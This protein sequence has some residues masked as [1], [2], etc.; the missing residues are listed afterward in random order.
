MLAVHARRLA[1]LKRFTQVRVACLRGAPRLAGVMAELTAERVY[2]APMLMADGFLVRTALSAAIS[3]LGREAARLRVAPVLGRNPRLA[4]RLLEHGLAAAR[5]RRWAPESARLL[6]IGHGT[7]RDRK[8]R[9]TAFTHAM[10]IA[11]RGVFAR[12]SAAFLEDR[13]TLAEAVAGDTSRLVAVG[14]FADAGRHGEDDVHRALSALGRPYAYA[15]AIG[16]VPAIAGLVLEQLAL[17]DRL[18]EAV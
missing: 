14:L 1:A 16:R 4:E 7:R 15:G 17:A 10:E 11:N 12:V 5:D 2:L 13:P 9:A 6:V 3:E 8:S 18:T